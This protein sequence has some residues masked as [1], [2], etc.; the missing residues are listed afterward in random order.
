MIPNTSPQIL[1]EFITEAFKGAFALIDDGHVGG[2]ICILQTSDLSSIT[3]RSRT[4]MPAFH[5]P[6]LSKS[7]AEIRTWMQ[8]HVH[9]SDTFASSTFTILDAE[10]IRNRTCRVGCVGADERMLT[11]DFFATLSVRIP[12]EMVV[13]SWDEYDFGKVYDRELIEAE[14]AKKE[15]TLEE[16]TLE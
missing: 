10:T 2:A 6:F 16:K 12:V 14:D 1:D 3:R 11:T 8:E 5:S 7:D 9:D 13:T 15:Q 4:P